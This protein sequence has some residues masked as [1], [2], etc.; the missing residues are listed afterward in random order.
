MDDDLRDRFRS[1][2]RDFSQPAPRP[3]HQSMPAQPGP[4][5]PEP[6]PHNTSHTPPPRP[7]N[8]H[9]SMPQNPFMTPS[10][11]RPT[12]M[13]PR[14]YPQPAHRAQPKPS[15]RPSTHHAEQT[16]QKPTAQYQ[17]RYEKPAKKTSRRKK[18]FIATSILLIV[19]TLAAGGVLWAYP[20]YNNQKAESQTKGPFSSDV[21]NSATF[22]LFYPG[23]LPPGYKVD[24]SSIKFANNVLTYAAS[25]SKG[26]RLVFTMQQI[27][28]QFN[29][30]QFYKEQLKES[31]EITTPYG[32]AVIGKNSNRNLG[33]MAVDNTWLLLSTNST[34][35]TADEMALVLQNLKQ[36]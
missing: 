31:E 8:E 25:N 26:Q 11:P 6:K 23:T 2:R 17:P 16:D 15:H 21:Q 12:N 22:K 3:H 34:E 27:A 36:R 20:K 5:H 13:H 9:H 1:D 35:V 30:N 14:A 19:G 4:D 33:S 29:F 18:W 10:Q 7:Q 28:P 32:K 24:E